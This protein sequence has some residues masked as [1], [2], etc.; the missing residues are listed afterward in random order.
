MI[1]FVCVDSKNGLMFNKRRQSQDV[2]LRQYILEVCKDNPIFMNQY[3]FK[4]FATEETENIVVEDEF[5]N[6]AG[7]EYCFVEGSPL[8]SYLS[9]ITT[10]FLC[11][12]NRD[13]PSDVTLDIDVTSNFQ[14]VSSVDIVGK[15][16]EKITIEEWQ[17]NE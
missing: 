1:V 10:L 2:Q 13:Y 11:K 14:M 5:L 6:H 8:E 7:E 4:Q 16:H 12:W 15:S 9:K 3:S 17:K